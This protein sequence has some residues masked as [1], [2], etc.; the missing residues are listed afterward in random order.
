[1]TGNPPPSGH[2]VARGVVMLA[3]IV[4]LAVVVA[5]VVRVGLL[6]RLVDAGGDVATRVRTLAD[7][8]PAGAVPAPSSQ[9]GTW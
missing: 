8:V 7:G 6:E 3:L 1:M 5:V 9:G 4:V 2:R